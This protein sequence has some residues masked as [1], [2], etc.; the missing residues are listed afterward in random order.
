MSNES[1]LKQVLMSRNGFTS[2]EA[3]EEISLAKEELNELLEDGETD[4]AYNICED[5]WGLE[6]DYLEDL[7]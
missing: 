2:E 6:P 3:D 4:A 1:R 5:M 7:I